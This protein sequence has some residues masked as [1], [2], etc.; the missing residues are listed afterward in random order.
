MKKILFVAGMLAYMTVFGVETA[1]AQLVPLDDAIRN[2][3]AELSAGIV[4]ESRVA[5]LSIEAGSVRMSDT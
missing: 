2:A 3:A 5:I 1:R 4:R